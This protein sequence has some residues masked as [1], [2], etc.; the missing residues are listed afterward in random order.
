[1]VEES[2]STEPNEKSSDVSS[3]P[4]L[5][6]PEPT[7]P[8]LPPKPVRDIARVLYGYTAL[9]PDELELKEGDMI[10]ILFKDCEDKG[11]WKGELN[12]KVHFLKFFLCNLNSIN[13]MMFPSLV[14]S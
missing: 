3:T 1:M 6:T 5:S 4:V 13:F 2:P 9:Q 8:K 11:W 7:A 10:T 12:G 14:V